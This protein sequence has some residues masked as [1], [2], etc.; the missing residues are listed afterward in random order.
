MKGGQGGVSGFLQFFKVC[1]CLCLRILTRP[2]PCPR[3]NSTSVMAPG[4]WRGQ[5]LLMTT[6]QLFRLKDGFHFATDSFSLSL[7]ILPSL[8]TQTHS[9][10]RPRK[11]WTGL[12]LSYYIFDARHVDVWAPCGICLHGWLL[13]HDLVLVAGSAW[14][15][16]LH[17][18]WAM[19]IIQ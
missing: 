2:P 8:S 15:L 14:T 12:T 11:F 17:D 3:D 1:V 18:V 16:T 5:L 10:S 9:S 7:F 6:S 4:S 19:Y 13:C